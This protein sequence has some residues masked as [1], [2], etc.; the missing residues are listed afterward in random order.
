MSRRRLHEDVF[1][2]HRA[3]GAAPEHPAVPAGVTQLLAGSRLR[4][5]GQQLR[6]ARHH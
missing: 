6:G 4:R 3:E 2:Q 5:A 1:P